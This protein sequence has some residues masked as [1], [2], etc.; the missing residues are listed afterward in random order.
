MR[1]IRI[2]IA[3]ELLNAIDRLCR[4]RRTTRS[5]LI[6]A[7]LETELEREAVRSEE[8]RHYAGYERRPVM[9]GEFDVWFDEQDWIER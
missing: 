8:N 7:A 6:C 1:T 4:T 5:A 2:T 9:T 3:E